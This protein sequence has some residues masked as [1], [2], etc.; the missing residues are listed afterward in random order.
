M[1]ALVEYVTAECPI[2]LTLVNDMVFIWVVDRDGEIFLAAEELVLDSLPKYIV[3]HQ[4]LRLTKNENKLGH[5]ALIS[6]QPGRIGGEIKYL[7]RDQNRE[8]SVWII[9]NGS[10]RYGVTPD[11]TERQLTNVNSRF[12]A[13]GMKFEID[14][15][16]PRASA[17]VV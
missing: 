3:K 9:N 15:I 5:P 7:H 16:R 11:R 12:A 2:N 1:K 6:C 10:G 4:D 13:L 8:R 14:F 17:R